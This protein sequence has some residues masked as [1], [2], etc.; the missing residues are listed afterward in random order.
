MS[1]KYK[2]AADLRIRLKGQL[3]EGFRWCHLHRTEDE[4]A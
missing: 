2:F 4:L 1:A 3:I